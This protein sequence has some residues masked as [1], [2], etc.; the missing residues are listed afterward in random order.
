M[1]PK[2]TSQGYLSTPVVNAVYQNLDNYEVVY[3]IGL[4]QSFS[5]PT[6][7]FLENDVVIDSFTLGTAVN[8]QT[9]I[10]QASRTFGSYTQ[11][12]TLKVRITNGIDSKTSSGLSASYVKVTSLPAITGLSA[13]ATRDGFSS[14]YDWGFDIPSYSM[15]SAS[16]FYNMAASIL[17]ES[18]TTSPPTSFVTVVTKNFT[19]PADAAS[20]FATY[21]DDGPMSPVPDEYRVTV[22]ISAAGYSVNAS[23]TDIPS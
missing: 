9:N 22:T 16:N 17:L 12:A 6:I 13:F 18:R 11:G 1:F 2:G 10:P 20:W 4:T 7:E 14:G 23:F 15:T 5:A 19:I 8:V 21:E 3:T